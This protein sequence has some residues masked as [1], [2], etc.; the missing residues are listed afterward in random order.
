MS[1]KESDILHSN[2]NCKG[3]FSSNSK[4]NG[5]LHSNIY[6]NSNATQYQ[7]HYQEQYQKFYTEMARV[8]ANLTATA[9]VK[10]ILH[11]DSNCNAKI[12]SNSNFT[13]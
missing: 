7:K 5:V 2:I 10:V 4:S 8:I 13:Q 9:K 12:I 3:K 11:S 6:S 1:G